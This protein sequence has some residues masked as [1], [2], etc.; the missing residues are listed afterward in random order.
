LEAY[1]AEL[2]SGRP[3]A[4]VSQQAQMGLG[5]LPARR[6]V[7]SR[8]EGP[9]TMVPIR[10]P[11]MAMPYPEKKK[12]LIAIMRKKILTN[13]DDIV[14][15]KD[16]W[17]LSKIDTNMVTMLFKCYARKEHPLY[18]A[19]GITCHICQF[20]LCTSRYLECPTYIKHT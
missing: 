6:R 13:P 1:R 16:K 15:L 12:K 10:G 4:P 3:R 2:L 5:G 17:L 14:N 7:Q 8:V 9:M 18:F 11:P 20:L 19:E